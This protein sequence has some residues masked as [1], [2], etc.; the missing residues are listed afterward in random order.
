MLAEYLHRVQKIHTR[1]HIENAMPNKYMVCIIILI[2]EAECWIYPNISKHLSHMQ[3]SVEWKK[4]FI[5]ILTYEIRQ[6][7]KYVLY[8]KVII[9]FSLFIDIITTENVFIHSRVT[10]TNPNVTRKI[11]LQI[12]LLRNDYPRTNIRHQNTLLYNHR[13]IDIKQ[14]TSRRPWI[15]Y[16]NSKDKQCTIL[17]IDVYDLYLMGARDVGL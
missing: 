12:L 13:G 8:N 4:F 10:Y 5:V 14:H 6:L 7:E 15:M 9:T 1:C 3:C 17:R 16:F 2:W 11:H